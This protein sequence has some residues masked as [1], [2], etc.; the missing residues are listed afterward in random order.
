[1]LRTPDEGNWT[2]S[3]RPNPE[4][5]GGGASTSFT[6]DLTP[7]N[8]VVAPLRLDFTTDIGGRQSWFAYANAQGVQLTQDEAMAVMYEADALVDEESPGIAAVAILGVIGALAWMRRHRS[9]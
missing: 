8:G 9:L 3:G 4:S 6:L 2:V 1:M 5:L 7:A